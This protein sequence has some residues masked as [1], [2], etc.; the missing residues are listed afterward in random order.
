MNKFKVGDLVIGNKENTYNITSEGT[1]CKV[2]EVDAV[3]REQVKVV[4]VSVNWDG[5]VM[6]AS[7][8]R[9]VTAKYF[10][11]YKSAPV[12]ETINR[13]APNI[14]STTINED[15]KK[16][17]LVFDKNDY[18]IATCTENDEFDPAVGVALALAYKCFGSKTKFHKWVDAQV[19]KNIKKKTG[20]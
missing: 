3:D 20:K 19:Q 8:A 18:S 15:K 12:S 9:W 13:I 1:I 16:V 6:E 2:V 7:V 14:K 11:L 5:E 17:T 4:V 10:D